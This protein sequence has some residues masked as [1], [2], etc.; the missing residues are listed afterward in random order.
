MN[1]SKEISSLQQDRP[2][3]FGRPASFVLWSNLGQKFWGGLLSGIGLGMFVT[4]F[5]QDLDMWNSSWV[6]FAAI[7]MLGGGTGLALRA[8]RS[9]MLQ[10][11][12]RAKN[13]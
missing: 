12:N 4:K 9:E 11:A 13:S 7:S 1:D 6:G 10:D 8:A 5:L 2:S 3:F